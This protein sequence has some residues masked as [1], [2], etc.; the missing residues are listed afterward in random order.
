MV[1]KRG[2]KKGLSD[3]I[4]TLIIILL[5]IVAVGIMW[6]VLRNLITKGTDQLST[7]DFT[8][9]LQIQKVTVNP[10]SVDVKVKLNQGEG[11]DGVLITISD[12]S[13]SNSSEQ[14][15]PINTQE[16]KT[17]SIPYTGVVSK[18]SVSPIIISEKGKKQVGQV[19]NS[20]EYKNTT[21]SSGSCTS[22]TT[23]TCAITNGQGTQT[24]TSG[25]WGTC[26]VV[27][28]NSGYQI[29][30][31]TNSCSA[32]TCTGVSSQACTITNGVGV[33]T[34]TCTSG[35]WSAWG[36]C[37]L[38]SCNS[39]YTQSGN[40]CVASSAYPTSGL[41]SYWK[42]DGN[43]NDFMGVNNGVATGVTSTSSGCTLNS[44]YSF[45]GTNSYINV[46]DST[47]LNGLSTATISVWVYP[48]TSLADYD[49]F[50]SKRDSF[51][52][53]F[54]NVAGEVRNDYWN[55][56]GSKSVVSKS[57]LL[58]ANNWH[59]IV[60]VYNGTSISL[61]INGVYINQTAMT[62][63]IKS[64]TGTAMAIGADIYS[65]ST[66][67]FIGKIDEVMIYNR[68]LSASEIQ[69]IYNYQVF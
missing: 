24:C 61:Y 7:S 52:L 64:S 39:G 26:T 30:L 14:M 3:V 62:G 59:H 68:A 36:T 11:V 12:G 67:G 49:G 25:T 65:P 5:V 31:T 45:S 22:S 41:I 38:V 60:S 2:N 35:T 50:V 57:P 58:T 20:Y 69:Q 51:T 40:T 56:T 28:C 23:Q 27:S 47:S 33:Q 6:V 4:T 55:A 44:C 9:D 1:S 54:H 32:V 46:A 34:R 10:T 53:G 29:N 48:T 42:L 43:T 19:S 8:T 16:E 15:I 18:V 37:T 63:S 66:R 21:S 13:N 17:F